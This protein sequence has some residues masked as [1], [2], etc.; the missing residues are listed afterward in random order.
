MFPFSRSLFLNHGIY[1]NIETMTTKEL[2]NLV[3]RGLNGDQQALSQLYDAYSHKMEIVCVKVVG[4]H[5]IAQELV[6]DAFILAFSKL[7]QLQNPR[8]FEQWLSSITTNVALRYINRNNTPQSISIAEITDEELY[9]KTELSNSNNTDNLPPF[10]VIMAAIDNLPEGYGK[11]FKMSVIQGMSHT[12]IAEILGIA[13]HSSSSQL[14]RAKKMLRKSLSTYWALLL[15]LLLIPITFLFLRNDNKEL[16]T[17]ATNKEEQDANSNTNE[18]T[19]PS[20]PVDTTKSI[21]HTPI[22]TTPHYQS[23]RIYTKEYLVKNAITPE[24][25][26]ATI[27][28]EN[29]AITDSVD[30][31]STDTI[32]TLTQPSTINP[33]RN[34][35]IADKDDDFD[36]LPIKEKT[37]NSKWNLHFAYSGNMGNNNSL[38]SPSQLPTTP[39]PHAGWPP[40]DGSNNTFTND[41]YYFL[42]NLYMWRE[43]YEWYPE[44]YEEYG[45]DWTIDELN[46]LI[47]IAEANINAGN[48]EITR[49]SHHDLPFTF[50]LALQHRLTKRWSIESGLSYT[51]LSS[52]FTTGEP[53]AGIIDNQEIHYLGIPLKASYNW[54]ENRQWSLYTSLGFTMDIPIYSSV[55]SDFVLNGSTLLH[56]KESLDMPLQWST[57]I[58]VG[59][60]YKVSTHFGIFAEPSFQYYIP[61]GSN[62]KTYRTEHPYNFSI[63]IGFRF[64][65]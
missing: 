31:T 21:D 65:W 41:W 33:N 49:E 25:S 61:D 47:K 34:I 15:A 1:D 5:M 63:P 43:E 27:V 16:P 23:K 46:A 56:Q 32:P 52:Q 42:H 10:E 60:Q 44:F 20:T 51:R 28:V 58:G 50:S 8:R 53:F 24:D 35:F 59:F 6:H 36:F 39:P 17:L 22:P 7:N 2:E 3:N 54:L 12:E 11:V 38:I 4:D 18:P 64:S 14:A 62:I 37:N 30:T 19:K 13:A 55:S 9:R 40:I 57:G 26:S 48:E 45:P 29:N